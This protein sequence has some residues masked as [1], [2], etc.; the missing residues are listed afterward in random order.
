MVDY[1]HKVVY[2]YFTRE[3]STLEKFLDSFENIDQRRLCIKSLCF[4]LP[5][6]INKIIEKI[7]QYDDIYNI[8]LSWN[9]FYIIPPNLFKLEYLY[10]LN[11]SHNYLT[12]ITDEIFKL[13]NLKILYID[14]NNFACFPK[15]VCKLKK[16]EILYVQNKNKNLEIPFEIRNLQKLKDSDF[17]KKNCKSLVIHDLQNIKNNK[18][19]IYRLFFI[20][21]KSYKFFKNNY[22]IIRNL[23]NF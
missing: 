11:L 10:M 8:D 6:S 22:K 23:I 15:N 3:Y 13:V 7:S 18:K 20:I 14:K 2:P 19:L 5:E 1:C 4:F 21:I 17:D 16:L 12:S 9:K